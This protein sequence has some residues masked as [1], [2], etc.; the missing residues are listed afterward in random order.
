MLNMSEDLQVVN[1]KKL[2]RFEIALDN[3]EFAVLQYRWLKGNM[4]LLHT[5]VPKSMQGKGIAAY[6]VKYVLD[7]MREQHFKAIVYCPYVQAYLKK[8]PEYNDVVLPHQA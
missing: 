2:F 7:Y 8:H 6:L 5:M 3:G 4:V 1:N